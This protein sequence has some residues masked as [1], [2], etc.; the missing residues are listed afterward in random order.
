[1]AQS[2]LPH[3]GS[4]DSL[5]SDLG[6]ICCAELNIEPVVMPCCG[7]D[8]CKTCFTRWSQ[9]SM[10]ATG[11]TQPAPCPLC[12]A[13]LPPTIAVSS[14]LKRQVEALLPEASKRRRQELNSS[15]TC[16]TPICLAP[17]TWGATDATLHWRQQQ[18][19]Q[20]SCLY[21]QWQQQQ[22]AIPVVGL[23]V[24]DVIASH[25]LQR[26]AQA[27]CP[28]RSCSAS[29]AATA[30]SSDEVV[31]PNRQDS[32]HASLSQASSCQLSAHS[33]SRPSPHVQ[34]LTVTAVRTVEAVRDEN[35]TG[36]H[37]SYMAGAG[38]EPLETGRW[39]SLRDVP[40]RLTVARSILQLLQARGAA[41]GG[42]AGGVLSAAALAAVQAIEVAL[43]R[44][45][46]NPEAYFD[47]NTLSR[48]VVQAVRAHVVSREAQRMPL[49]TPV[50]NSS[51]QL[52]S[53]CT[54]TAID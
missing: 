36:A 37:F 51:A 30:G 50:S 44:S 3:D 34:H 22:H 7:A 10:S 8:L 25:Y 43:Y 14:R 32:T 1:M 16:Y 52:L 4:L 48:R 39:Q 35:T 6:C 26:S 24:A 23:P 53:P 47:T 45:A 13:P 40:K 11:W 49:T 9:A 41:G 33:S 28:P 29:L 38:L 18:L 27:T 5:E 2:L 54:G 46:P 17:L 20:Q 15:S 21:V 19:W 31:E 42:A 12:R